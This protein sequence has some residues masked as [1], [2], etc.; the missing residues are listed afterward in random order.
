MTDPLFILCPIRSFSS[1]VCTMV[2]Q[3][4]DLYGFPELRLFNADTLDGVLHFH[5]K[6]LAIEESTLHGSR[7]GVIASHILFFKLRGQRRAM[8]ARFSDGL[9]RAVA[10]LVCGGQTTEGVRAAQA[11]L[12][13]R[14]DWSV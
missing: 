4:P 7:D 14:L 12:D 1:I 10:E 13:A 8:T 3:H 5:E 2:G 6:M 9:L 11:W